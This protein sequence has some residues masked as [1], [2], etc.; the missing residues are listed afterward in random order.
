MVIHTIR[1]SRANIYLPQKEDAQ[2]NM[3]IPGAVLVA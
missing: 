2:V 3:R 1:L